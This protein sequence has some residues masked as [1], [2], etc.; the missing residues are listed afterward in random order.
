MA[1][2]KKRTMRAVKKKGFEGVYA[3]IYGGRVTGYTSFVPDKSVKGGRR[4]LKTW[5]TATEARDDRNAELAKGATATSSRMTL[6]EFYDQT[7]I[8]HHVDK[9]RPGSKKSIESGLKAF[10]AEYGDTPANRLDLDDIRS[11]GLTV[12]LNQAQYARARESCWG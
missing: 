10:L 3:R 2:P 8:P 7:Y 11:W 6:K 1:R 5:P 4:Q 9:L 12:A